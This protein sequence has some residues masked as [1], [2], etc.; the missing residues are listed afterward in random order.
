[1]LVICLVVV[2][3]LVWCC[4][5]CWGFV[6]D[7]VGSQG[8]DVFD[9]MSWCEFELFVGEGFRLQGYYVIEKGGGGFDG[10]VD[11]VLFWLDR[12]GVEKF[13]V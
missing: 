10:G 13:L 12:N 11:L 1:M 5:M 2:G 9:G 3:V 6:V 4:K 8:Y 7:V